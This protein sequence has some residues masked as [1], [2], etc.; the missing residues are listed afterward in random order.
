MSIVPALTYAHD[1]WC[2]TGHTAGPRQCPPR[3]EV[4]GYCPACNGWHTAPPPTW[5]KRGDNLHHVLMMT[6]DSSQS[7]VLAVHVLTRI[8]AYAEPEGPL[9][10]GA[11]LAQEWRVAVQAGVEIR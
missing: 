1:S 5:W 8:R 9:H 4:G 2:N 6:L 11:L 3:C 10:E 7:S